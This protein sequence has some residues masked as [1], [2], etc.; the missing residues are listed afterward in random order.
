MGTVFEKAD[1]SV[2]AIMQK[3]AN[4]YHGELVKAK[5][6]VGLLMASADEG[7]TAVK[8]HG[9]PC[10]AIIKITPYKQRVHGIEDAVITIDQ[11]SWDELDDR[12]RAALIDH[13]LTHLEPKLDQGAQVKTDDLGRPKLGI[14][15]HDAQV[16][17]FKSVIQRH[18]AAALDAQI[19]KDFIAE[20]EQLLLEFANAD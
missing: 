18:G 1:D 8:L 17:I 5:V 12:Q 20:Y 13:E 10:A 6:S 3:V 14:V 15:L 4:K 19:A 16:G 7:E 2:M 11:K 9:Y